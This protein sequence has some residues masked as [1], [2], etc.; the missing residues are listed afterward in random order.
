[1][2]NRIGVFVCHCGIN[3]ASTVNVNRLTEYAKTLDGV[4]VS[5][6]YKYMCSDVGA[7]LIKDSIKKHKLD[8]VVIACCSPRMHEYTFRD[9]VESGG[10]SAFNLEIANVREQCSWVHENKE[11]ATAKAESIVRG[12]VAKAK[13]LEPLQTSK[14]SVTPEAL[15]IGGGIAG[16]QAALDLA[17]EN[18]KVYL[19]EK[20]PSIGGRMAQLD[21]TFPTLDCSGCI[22]TPKMMEVA[23][24]SNIELLTYSE[25]TSVEGSIGNYNVKIKK[26]ARYVDT[27]KC[28]G[29]G[30]CVKAC[31]MKD[32]VTS[33]FDMGLGKRS[34]IYL[35]FPQAI[36]LKCTIDCDTCLMLTR[37]KCGNGP[38]CVEACEAKAIDFKQKDEEIDIKV[39]SII[40]ATGYDIMDPY[41]LYEYGYACS[42][43]VITTLEMER[44]ISSSG[45]TNGEII[46]PSNGEKPKSITFILCV[47]SR[48]ET[49]CTWCCRI[50]CMSALKQVYLL[51]E[52]LGDDVEINVCYTDIRSFGKGY[53]EFYRNIRGMKTNFFRGRPSEVR[54]AGNHLTI[55]IFDTTTNKL[56][57]INTDL[58]VLVPELV[59]RKD[60]DKIAR[61]L[62][63]S[64]SAD[65]FFLEAHPKLRPMDTFTRGIFIAGCCQAPK[66]IQDSVAQASGAAARAANILS[67]KELES[68]PLVSC[69]DEELCSGC[70]TCI[71]VC[72]YKAIDLVKENDGKSR[73]KINEALCMGCGACV[74]AC[75]SGAMQQR[76][77]K[78][79]QLLPMVDETI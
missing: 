79:K 41:S 33:E 7:N 76:G 52:K 26:K 1:M 19:V 49:E 58:V 36:P 63:I 72:T 13:L 37:G 31:R 12:A 47:G 53:E 67:K 66:D 9:V 78:D 59:P 35:P 68:E 11:R 55:D 74:C 38:L 39:G 21:K 48:D 2:G 54:N 50:G 10:V 28:T 32:H 34:A 61:I 22:L 42:N 25:V 43:D 4:V 77:F 30:D 15:V 60:S 73:A 69:V 16:I 27:N 20:S 45:P 56:F 46:K 29:C 62:R 24:N 64:Q 71:S 40:V 5:K 6:D 8:G 70:A 57:E 44:L 23:N 51:K 75:P 18:H 17:E 3:I 65:G 14:I